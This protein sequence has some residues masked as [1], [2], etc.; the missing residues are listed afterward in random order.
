MNFDGNGYDRGSLSG[1][2]RTITRVRITD[3]MRK[4][5]KERAKKQKEKNNSG[6][7]S[8]ADF[9]GCL[10]EVIVEH[11][12]NR[13]QIRFLSALDSKKHDYILKSSQYTFDVKTK[14]RNF[15]PARG[16]DCT[17][18]FYNHTYQDSHFFLFV[19]LKSFR[20]SKGLALEDKFEF[21]F[22]VGSITY[23]ELKNIGISYL[24]DEQ[25]WTNGT[26]M[27]TTALNVLMYQLISVKDTVSLFKSDKS[28]LLSF[29][30]DIEHNRPTVVPNVKANLDLIT[31][32]Q[33]KIESKQLLNRPFPP[34]NDEKHK[35][36]KTLG[37]K[38]EGK[39]LFNPLDK[40]VI[41]LRL[42]NLERDLVKS[43]KDRDVFIQN[44]RGMGHQLHG[45]A[46]IGLL[47]RYNLFWKGDCDK[48]KNSSIDIEKILRKG[49]TQKQYLRNR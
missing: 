40:A 28:T 17:V 5:A 10:G 23:E 13:N 37:K 32:M 12:M 35:E 44:L 36:L 3:D 27:W 14:D 43:E 25:D 15:E 8:E 38:I 16:Y 1:K 21:G 34:W 18:P 4:V 29:F 49:K 26:V 9:K 39:E 48:L 2:D 20:E 45:R 46:L 22:I 30:E 33:S 42:S 7:G 6:L 41:S 31:E 11:W 24:H 47:K 19:S